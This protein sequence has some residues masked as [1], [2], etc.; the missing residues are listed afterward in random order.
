M[1]LNIVVVVLAVLLVLGAV[2]VNARL[3]GQSGRLDRLARI[4]GKLDALLGQLDIRYDPGAT[5][6]LNVREAL[7]RGQ[8]IEAIKRLRAATGLGLKEA[9]DRIDEVRHQR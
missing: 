9:K 3:S 4:E 6:P 5:L 2:G 7:D 1:D 8:T